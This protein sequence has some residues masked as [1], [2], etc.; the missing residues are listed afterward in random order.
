ML[1][2]YLYQPSNFSPRIRQLFNCAPNSDSTLRFLTLGIASWRHYAGILV[3]ML[4]IVSL[5]AKE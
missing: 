3:L 2:L 1:I 4:W 5:G